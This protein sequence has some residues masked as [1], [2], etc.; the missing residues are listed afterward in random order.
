MKGIILITNFFEDTEA[1]TTVDV[2]K[3]AGV[4]V[5]YVSLKETKDI[6]TQYN[7]KIICDKLFSEVDIKKYDFLIIPGGRAV[8]SELV[9]MNDVK[10]AIHHFARGGKLVATIC[11]APLLVG[12]L[13]YLQDKDY[14]CF[15]GC[16][17][18]IIGGKKKNVGV[19]TDAN[20]ITGKSMAYSVEF[21]LAI[22]EY[23]LGKDTR[24]EI[25]KHIF[26]E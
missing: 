1:I 17:K 10:D 22:I 8:M 2:L 20:F 6:T 23:L 24:K 15:P 9:N 12:E 11:A 7:L 19:V 13:G 21:A 14:T 4:E 25:K 16:E 3:R 26:G 5:D 18:T